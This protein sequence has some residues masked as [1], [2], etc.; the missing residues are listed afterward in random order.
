MSD[1]PMART[2]FETL[3]ARIV[4]G[5]VMPGTVM[6]LEE[7]DEEFGVSRSVTREAVKLLE[8][9][10]LVR[11][12]RRV[13]IV[14]S[15]EESWDVSSPSVIEWCLSGPR[16][17]EEIVW[18]SEVRSAMEPLAARLAAQRADRD[19]AAAMALAVSGMTSAAADGDLDE[20]L[21]HDIDFH[22]ALL[23][24]SHNPL[25]ASHVRIVVAVLEGRTHLMPF[26]PKW[27]AIGWHRDIA[28]A[29]A[30]HDPGVADEAM[31]AIVTEAW[32]AMTD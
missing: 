20:Y 23:R 11:A 5:A 28:A 27:E 25:V 21:R 14:V 17:D 26:E 10:S 12:R 13:G 32:Q 19:E 4:N 2:V 24:A 1:A 22:T 30:A 7:I 3:G 9:L 31:R 16:R 29:V 6:R 18:I 8:A 15:E